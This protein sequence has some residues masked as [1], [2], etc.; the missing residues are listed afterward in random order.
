MRRTWCLRLSQAHVHIHAHLPPR[1]YLG[2][3]QERIQE[4]QSEEDGVPTGRKVHA[5]QEFR[6]FLSPKSL[7]QILDFSTW[8]VP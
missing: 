1:L 2:G 8:A 5:C 7:S 4:K 6:E 3:N